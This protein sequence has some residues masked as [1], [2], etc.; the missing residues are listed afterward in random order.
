[1][2]IC[3]SK[4][5]K[6]P[7]KHSFVRYYSYPS[8]FDVRE[9]NLPT[10]G[11]LLLMLQ[12]RSLR[13]M[14]NPNIKFGITQDR[15]QNPTRIFILTSYVDEFKKFFRMKLWCKLIKLKEKRREKK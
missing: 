15:L 13:T 4:I 12:N 3:F 9:L 1:M 11:Q 7:A 6:Y 8:A 2:R 10:F 5:K 14:T